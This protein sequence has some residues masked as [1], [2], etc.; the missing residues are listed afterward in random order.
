MIGEI[1]SGLYNGKVELITYILNRTNRNQNGND[2]GVDTEC[3]GAL[4]AE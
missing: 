1:I 4:A 2:I 3:G